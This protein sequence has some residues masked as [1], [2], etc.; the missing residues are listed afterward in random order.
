[1]NKL[2]TTD[3]PIHDLP[4]QRWSPRAFADRSV[5][6]VTLGALVFTGSWDAPA[7]LG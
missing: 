1:M 4:A 7:E 5:A 6:P 3:Y 2:A